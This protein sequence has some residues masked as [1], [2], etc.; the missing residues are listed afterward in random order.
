MRAPQAT[1]EPM[2]PTGTNPFSATDAANVLALLDFIVD[3]CVDST[4]VSIAERLS[5]PRCHVLLRQPSTSSYNTDKSSQPGRQ[6][7]PSTVCFCGATRSHYFTVRDF[8]TRVLW[9]VHPDTYRRLCPPN[10]K[11]PAAKARDD[12]YYDKCPDGHLGAVYEIICNR[13]RVHKTLQTTGQS[14]G[15]GKV[16]GQEKVSRKCRGYPIVGYVLPDDANIARLT[17]QMRAVRDWE[18]VEYE[19]LL[20]GTPPRQIEAA[21]C[22]VPPPM[23]IA[24][25][26]G[27][28]SLGRATRVGQFESLMATGSDIFPATHP[29]THVPPLKS[30]S[31][32]SDAE[33]REAF[34]VQ[35]LELAQKITSKTTRRMGLSESP[36]SS[37]QP[38]DV[39][40]RES[41]VGNSLRVTLG[42]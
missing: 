14:A 24:V 3:P 9:R 29:A 22:Q 31:A 32:M 7:Q 37:T 41:V 40:R 13:L 18:L 11:A 27:L 4:T 5:D 28:S 2:A 8:A 25:A 21:M 12:K 26:L 17:L 23:E 16:S 10:G 15:Q 38:S 42:H 33:R 35:E 1:R 19:S 20:T 36:D 6:P 39:L 34:I 30:E